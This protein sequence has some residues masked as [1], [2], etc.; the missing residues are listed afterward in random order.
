MRIAAAAAAVV[1]MGVT[2]GCGEKSESTTAAPATHKLDLVLDWFPNP[3]HVAIF[4]AQQK[5]F[6]KQ[7]GLDVSTHVPSDP[8]APIKQVAAGRSELAI[9]YEPEVLLAREQGLPVTSVA[10]LVQRPLTSLIAT[11][12]SGVRSVRDLR[13]KRVGT[14]GIPYQSAY[15]K[16]ILQR[17]H[18]PTSSVKETNVGASLL[19]AMLSRKVD[20]TL[21]GFWNVEGVELRQRGE[22]PTVI[23]VDK[24]GVPEYDE[25]V[26]VANKDKLDDQRDD[27][28]LFIAAV[29][30][31]A[32]AARQDPAGATKALLEANPDLKEKRARESVRLTIP[33]LFPPQRADPWGYMDPVAWRNYGGWMVDQGILKQLPDIPNAIT[34]DLLP[35]Q[36]LK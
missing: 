27:L 12:K 7:V 30:R 22:K 4:E 34:N 19:P 36:G 31:G 32:E 26:F 33:T 13:G 20:A 28:R 21:G 23:P 18:V 16:T 9:S 25:L 1:L 5:G 8:A 35:G 11:R 14:A 17:A 6:F 3:D 29:A 2:A 24:L 15:L 10:A